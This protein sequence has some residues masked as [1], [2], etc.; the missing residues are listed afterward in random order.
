MTRSESVQTRFP[1]LPYVLPFG[2]FLGFL[3]L[4][5]VV[6]I[7]ELTDQIIWILG[8]TLV[9]L[10]ISRPVLD[11]RVRQWIGSVLIGILVFIIWIGPDLLLPGYR[12]FW[13]FENFIAGAGRSAMLVTGQSRPAVMALRTLRAVAVVPI[14]EE[15]FWRA[16]LMRWIISDNFRK[17]PLGTYTRQ[18]FWVVAVLFA[19]EHGPY[20]E[21]GLVAGILYNWWMVRTKNLGDLILTHAVTNACLSAY[22]MAA[23]KWEFWL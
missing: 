2:V 20:W 1:S 23:G 8:M 5:A 21:V 15:L 14:I 13:L 18:S 9:V 17:V 11:F 12:H 19:S 7:P 6:S 3:G 16:W 10:W 22:V 4:H